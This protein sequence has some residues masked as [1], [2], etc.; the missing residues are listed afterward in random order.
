M[1]YSFNMH[2]RWWYGYGDMNSGAAALASGNETQGWS[3]HSPTDAKHVRLFIY[4]L[5]P[6]V[7]GLF[8]ALCEDDVDAAQKA[9]RRFT[10]PDHAAI[11]S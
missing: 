9:I 3:A 8:G 1:I 6:S 10:P 4:A 7:Y 5:M 11:T 2:R